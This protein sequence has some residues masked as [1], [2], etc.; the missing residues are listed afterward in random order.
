MSFALIKMGGGRERERRKEV[1][2]Y[3]LLLGLVNGFMSFASSFSCWFVMR[4]GLPDVC[5]FVCRTMCVTKGVLQVSTHA[6]TMYLTTFMQKDVPT[7]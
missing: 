5:V 2:F 3:F 4:L 6:K 1:G 7:Y